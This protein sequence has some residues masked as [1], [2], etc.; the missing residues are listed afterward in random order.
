MDGFL[1]FQLRILG[2]FIGTVILGLRGSDGS[3][4]NRQSGMNMRKIDRDGS[5]IGR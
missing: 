2:K 4:P 1:Q 5:G 3:W